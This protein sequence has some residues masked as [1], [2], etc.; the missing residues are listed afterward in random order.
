MIVTFIQFRLAS[1]LV[2]AHKATNTNLTLKHRCSEILLEEVGLMA[3]P[4][5]IYS[6]LMRKSSWAHAIRILVRKLIFI[7]RQNR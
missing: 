5:D 4:D 3:S 2:M 7:Y 1:M 6:G